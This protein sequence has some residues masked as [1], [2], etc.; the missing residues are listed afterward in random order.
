MPLLNCPSTQNRQNPMRFRP[1]ASAMIVLITASAFAI[2]PMPAA[3]QQPPKLEPLPAAPPPPP[4]VQ[5]DLGEPPVR[6]GPGANDQVEEVVRAG[7][8]AIKVTRPDGSVYYMVEEVEPA[9][10]PATTMG[11]GLR[12]PMW[13]IFEF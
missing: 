2:L 12:A 6:I 4:G 1:L 5:D 3:A 13:R 11:P 7:K 8:R 9:T 10:G